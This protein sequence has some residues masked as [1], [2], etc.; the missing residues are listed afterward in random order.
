MT[1]LAGHLVYD[2]LKRIVLRRKGKIEKDWGGNRTRLLFDNTGR[3]ALHGYEDVFVFT[4]PDT[5]AFLESD[6]TC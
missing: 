1:H 3:L 5:T 4:K 2:V 6:L